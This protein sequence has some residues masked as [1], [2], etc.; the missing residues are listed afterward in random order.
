MVC[1]RD[2]FRPV[3]ILKA[4]WLDPH[5]D[6]EAARSMW[7]SFMDLTREEWLGFWQQGYEYCG[8][9]E[10][11]TLLARAAVLRYRRSAAAAVRR[12][13]AISE[14]RQQQRW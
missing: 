5:G 14:T 6:Y 1:H 8:I 7:A 2:T 3:H 12:V 4:R 9:F 10:D 13:I 11:R